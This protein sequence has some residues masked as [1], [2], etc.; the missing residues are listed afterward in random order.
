MA[1]VEEEFGI[2]EIIRGVTLITFFTNWKY[3][4]YGLYG[5]VIW[6]LIVNAIL[7][8]IGYYSLNGSFKLGEILER[9]GYFYNEIY[10]FVYSVIGSIL[11]FIGILCFGLVI[12]T[13]LAGLFANPLSIN[14]TPGIW[15]N[16]V[17][18]S[19]WF[20]V[21]INLI[22]SIIAIG[23]T[24]RFINYTYS[25][26]GFILVNFIGGFLLGNPILGLISGIIYG[27]IATLIIYLLD[28]S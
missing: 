13:I 19:F 25:Y 26:L 4:S 6:V 8:V 3:L 7:T 18:N 1:E 24:S 14:N 17:T 5:H 10:E 21:I 2:G 22:W 12:L 11:A 9:G 16:N 27:G 15:I 23:I 28:S 20:N